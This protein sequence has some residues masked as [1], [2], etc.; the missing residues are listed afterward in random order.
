[1]PPP[2]IALVPAVIARQAEEGAVRG[3]EFKRPA[4]RPYV[5]VVI[6]GTRSAIL[7]ET[8]TA[9]AGDRRPN[10]KRGRQRGR[11]RHD[12]VSLSVG[13]EIGP[14]GELGL[15]GQTAGDV[16][17]CPAD[18]IAAVQR[19]LRTA[20]NFD[21]LDVVDVEHRGLRA[22]EI[23]VVEIKADAL[24]EA[25][26]R[27]LLPDP[28]DKGGERRVGPA[29]G[30]DGDVRGGRADVGDVQGALT[31][32]LLASKSSDGDRD[33]DQQ[34]VAAPRGDDDVGLARLGRIG[35]GRRGVRGSSSRD[36]VGSRGRSMGHRRT[37]D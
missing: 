14:N 36:G 20:Q 23:N 8:S 13:A 19:A 21:P 28:A 33:V 30:F 4:G 22:I 1:M 10:A 31:C 16:F 15:V 2:R 35:L 3:L 34:F 37:C 29:R 7:A 6:V 27:V 24:F 9:K 5:L 32:Q 12:K 11:G 26:Y 17:D 25:R 18:S